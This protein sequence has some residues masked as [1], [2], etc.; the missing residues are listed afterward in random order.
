LGLDLS[1]GMLAV[2]RSR[3]YRV[4]LIRADADSGLPLK[5][6]AVDFA[7][8]VDVVHHL[9][10]LDN[11]FRE[12]FRVLKLGGILVIVTDSE[13]NIRTRSL[14]RCFPEILQVEL[15]RYPRLVDLSLCA[16]RSGLDCES[17][18]PAE[19]YFEIDRDFI[20]RVEDKCSSA[21]R[22]IS[23]EAHRA[24]VARLEEARRRGEK[25]FSCYTVLRF[26]KPRSHQ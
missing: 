13:E 2:A 11:L 14:T 9:K 3:S 15:Q 24:G 4:G 18:E 22:L 21:M 25:W 16:R 7:F 1:S 26:R 19:G 23:D 20:S 6:E 12:V 8:L 17:A 10:N 5:A